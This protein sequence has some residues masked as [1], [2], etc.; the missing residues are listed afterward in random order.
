ME[1]VRLLKAAT[2]D[3]KKG[4]F[5]GRSNW[6]IEVLFQYSQCLV[7]IHIPKHILPSCS[8]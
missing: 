1:E 2:D 7:N 5:G 3:S 4:V 6:E 8:V